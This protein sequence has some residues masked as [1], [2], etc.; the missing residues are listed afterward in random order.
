MGTAR[1]IESEQKMVCSYGS[2]DCGRVIVCV[3]RKDCSEQVVVSAQKGSEQLTVGA[4]E[5]RCCCF[6][7]CCCC[8]Y[9]CCCSTL[10][11]PVCPVADCSRSVT[12]HDDQPRLPPSP[13]IAPLT[14]P[15]SP[16]SLATVPLLSVPAEPDIVGAGA[17]GPA[18]AAWAVGGTGAA[19]PQSGFHN[20]YYHCP[21]QHPQLPPPLCNT[22][23]SHQF[24]YSA[25]QV[26]ASA[27]TSP[28]SSMGTP[29]GPRRTLPSSL[30]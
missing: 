21:H 20:L 29:G 16:P 22:H 10:T 17:A 23:Y 25:H 9:C 13:S 4:H 8:C 18:G 12:D 3:L 6:Y 26:M 7:S 14:P 2:K 11:S 24:M 27:A 28:I 19:V 30:I 15:M 1:I 5:D